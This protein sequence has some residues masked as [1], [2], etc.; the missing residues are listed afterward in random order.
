MPTVEEALQIGWKQHQAGNLRG[1]ED[2]Y[3]QVLAVAPRNENAWCFLG[4]ACHDLGRYEEAGQAYREALRIRPN[5]PVA[6]SNFGNTLKQQG[7]LE[8]AEASCREALRYKPDYSTAYNNLGVVLVAQGRLEDASAI[9]EK[10]LSLMP[11]DVV[12][13]ANLGAALVRQGRYHEG[14][15]IA[16]RAL[17]INPNYAE[18]HKNQAIVWLLLGDYARGWAEYEWRWRCPGSAPPVVNGPRWDGSPVAGRT[19]L[20]HWEQGLGDTLQFIRYARHFQREGAKVVVCCQK[21]LKALLARCQG[22]DELVAAGEPLPRFDWWIPLLSVP[23]ILQTTVETVPV[24]GAYLSADPDLTQYWR[25]RLDQYPGFRIGIAWQGSRD[26]HADRQRSMP[27]A[28]FEPLARV[29]GVRLISL[30]KGYGSEQ[31]TELRDRFEVIDFAKELDETTGPFLD[32][33]ALIS[34]LDLVISADTSIGHLAGALGAPFWEALCL[35]P[36]WRW[37]LRREDSP[38]Y[39]TVRLFR[40][41]KLG[42][43]PEVFQRMADVLRARLA[44][45]PAI[46]PTVS[47]PGPASPSPE[48]AAHDVPPSPPTMSSVAP[49]SATTATTATLPT[50]T[51]PST[52]QPDSSTPA[53]PASLPAGRDA[54]GS[55]AIPVAAGTSVPGSTRLWSAGNQTLFRTCSG[56]VWGELANPECVELLEYLEPTRVEGVASEIAYLC[57]LVRAGDTVVEVGAGLGARTIPFARS[58]GSAGA[59]VAFEPDR[60]A[61]QNLLANAALNGLS[62]I[63]G[64]PCLVWDPTEGTVSRPRWYVTIDDLRLTSCRLL[65]YQVPGHEL[66]SLMAAA[67]TILDCQPMIYLGSIASSSRAAVLDWLAPRG[68]QLFQR[69]AKRPTGP[70]LHWCGFPS[71]LL[72]LATGL[73]PVS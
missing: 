3:R 1:A 41:T 14:T 25:R 64:H 29:P 65:S 35:S 55:V 18:A 40:Q 45:I 22:I 30:Q 58:V 73:T 57:S 2:I 60:L 67:R 33:A 6:L 59:V 50:A 63:F 8:E 32:T 47:A 27:V 26:F 44:P 53:P 68:Y 39:P 61:F 24:E 10:S 11:N 21:P 4:M 72:E 28:H 15:E 48:T 36:D 23:G 52:S 51:I 9:F 13:Q 49:Q 69:I 17:K 43:W 70:E 66:V 56:V 19:I 34:S 16:Q 62:N 12:A 37:L 20:L 31:L 38:W 71:S 46:T 7:K 54:N 42:E 5:F